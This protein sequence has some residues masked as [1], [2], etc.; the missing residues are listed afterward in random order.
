MSIEDMT[1]EVGQG[2]MCVFLYLE[3]VT[4]G[5]GEEWEEQLECTYWSIPDL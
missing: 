1:K 4:E 2:A 5:G 3:A